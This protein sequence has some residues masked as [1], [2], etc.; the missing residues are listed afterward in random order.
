M[1]IFKPISIADKS[2]FDAAETENP[3][4]SSER[5]F[6]VNYAYAED[7]KTLVAP[8]RGRIAVLHP[9]KR[10]LHYPIGK[11][12]SPEE[13]LEY[14]RDVA[15]SGYTFDYIYDTP[16]EFPAN[17]PD[18]EKLF[19]IMENEGEFDY[20]FDL[21][22][23][24][25]MRG[26][27]LR[28]KRNLIKHF[29]TENPNWTTEDI[30]GG[31]IAQAREF[32]LETAADFDMSAIIRCFDTFE[33]MGLS[34]LLLRDDNG[35]IVGLSVFSRIT[36]DMFDVLFEKS[37]KTEKG[38]AQMLVKLETEF[39]IKQ[40]ALYMNREQDLGEPNL[41]QAKKSLDPSRM[42]KR[43]SVVPKML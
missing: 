14:A 15:T 12:V 10:I 19:D 28:K 35:K 27:I 37:D 6:A 23:L 26:A 11:T 24:K 22:N 17:Y 41:R 38:A 40:N 25:E 3:S 8:W 4:E 16:P 42:Y 1:M 5:T 9:E 29:E 32:A 33:Q 34:G 2:A 39:L 30:D 31:N 36:A 18:A 7:Y 13:L 43:L 20:I 21:A